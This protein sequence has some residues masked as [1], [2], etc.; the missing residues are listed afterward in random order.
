[1]SFGKYEITVVFILVYV[2]YVFCI[3]IVLFKDVDVQENGVFCTV[4]TKVDVHVLLYGAVHV[5]L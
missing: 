2:K 5:R 1:M 3:Y 4:L